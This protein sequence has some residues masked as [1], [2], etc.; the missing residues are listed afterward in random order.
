MYP[1]YCPFLHSFCK[2]ESCALFI[3]NS[4]VSPYACA[5]KVMAVSAADP[6]ALKNISTVI[7][8]TPAK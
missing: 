3:A 2:G 5:I 8:V 6:R 1:K 7:S 4:P